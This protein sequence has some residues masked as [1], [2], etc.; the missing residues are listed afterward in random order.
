MFDVAVQQFEEAVKDKSPQDAIG[1]IIA[2]IAG[3]Q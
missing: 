1:G 2:A 3:V